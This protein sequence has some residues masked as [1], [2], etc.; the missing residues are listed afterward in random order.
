[1]VERVLGAIWKSLAN[2]VFLALAATVLIMAAF[3]SSFAFSL[4]STAAV[5][6]SPVMT[7]TTGWMKESLREIKK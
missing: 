6:H 5:V 2:C 4:G 3:W 7:N 1:M